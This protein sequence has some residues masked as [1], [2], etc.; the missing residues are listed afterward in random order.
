MEKLITSIYNVIW[1]N[2]LVYLCL[3]SGVYFSLRTKFS[4]VRNLKTMVK[5]LLNG[6]KSEEGIS[7]FQGFCTALADRKSVV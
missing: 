6:E 2:W 7:S 3:L 1:S 4:Q 5:L